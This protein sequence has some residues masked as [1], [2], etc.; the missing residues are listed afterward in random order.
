MKSSCVQLLVV[1]RTDACPG[2]VRVVFVLLDILV[3]DPFLAGLLWRHLLSFSKV[4]LMDLH[5]A[6]GVLGYFQSPV[7]I[8]TTGLSLTCVFLGLHAGNSPQFIW[9][10]V[11]MRSRKPLF[12]SGWGET[13]WFPPACIFTPP[14][15]QIFYFFNLPMNPHQRII[16]SYCALPSLN[17]CLR[18]LELLENDPRGLRCRHRPRRPLGLKPGLLP[19]MD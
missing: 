9:S 12:F 1:L 19:N 4:G 3:T 10:L 2:S 13:L 15:E 18:G 14:V 8:C 16:C 6:F 11:M 5:G 17:V 7:L